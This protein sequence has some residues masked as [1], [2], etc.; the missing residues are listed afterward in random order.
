MLKKKEKE[1]F[2]EEIE[3]SMAL[4]A[5]KEEAI[6]TVTNAF[7]EGFLLGLKHA[8]TVFDNPHDESLGGND[9]NNS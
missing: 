7:N 5:A 4:D 8:K 6:K 2:F 9:E 1:D 3:V